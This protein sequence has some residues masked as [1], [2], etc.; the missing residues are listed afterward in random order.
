MFFCVFWNAV[1]DQGQP[2][3]LQHLEVIARDDESLPNYHALLDEILYVVYTSTLNL[4]F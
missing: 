1:G 2:A 4:F 3:Q